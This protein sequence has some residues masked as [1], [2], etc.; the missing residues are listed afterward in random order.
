M[1]ENQGRKWN[2][3]EDMSAEQ[4]EEGIV[5]AVGSSY[6]VMNFFWTFSSWL[7]R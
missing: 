4:G 5:R 2:F 3:R 1:G 7:E 6:V